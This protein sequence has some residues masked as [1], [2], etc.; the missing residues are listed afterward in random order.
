M[1]YASETLSSPALRKLRASEKLTLGF[2][3]YLVLA[4]LFFPVTTRERLVILALNA[5]AASTVVALSRFAD[6]ERSRV[7]RAAR[8][9]LPAVLLLVAY[10]ESGLFATPDPT[11][12]FDQILIQWDRAILGHSWTE[13]LLHAGAPWLQWYLEL[14]YLLCYPLVPM[15][16]GALLL[17]SRRRSRVGMEFQQARVVDHYWL[18]V[19]AASFTC[20][21]IFPH[22]PLTPP[23]EL[24]SD[25]PG[26]AVSPLL[27]KTNFWLLGQYGVGVCLFP[28]AHVASTLAAGLVVRR[29]APKVGIVFL[30]AAISIAFATVYGRYH[31]AADAFAGVLVAIVAYVLAAKCAAASHRN[32]SAGSHRNLR[33]GLPAAE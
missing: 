16:L 3:A 19:L 25:L 23:R 12:R 11:H 18:A 6:P 2:L 26:P 27:R 8:D 24:F 7:L 33:H 22:V 10:R 9:W 4:S 20:Y 29:Y 5:L 17:V 21:L 13:A 32:R 30:V 14:A 28:S 1:E 15:G 31:Y